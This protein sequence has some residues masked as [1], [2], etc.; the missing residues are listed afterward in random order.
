MMPI[1]P[2]GIMFERVQVEWQL[3]NTGQKSTYVC[4]WPGIA[5]AQRWDCPNGLEKRGVPGYPIMLTIGGRQRTLAEYSDLLR[6]CGF[7][8]TREVDTQA[9]VSIIEAV[10]V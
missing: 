9:G 8:M 5:F 7:A 4:Q 2:V 3:E 1:P 10:P 6:Q